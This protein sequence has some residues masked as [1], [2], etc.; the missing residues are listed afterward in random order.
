MVF[1]LPPRVPR[2]VADWPKEVRYYSVLK[3]AVTIGAIPYYVSRPLQDT[4][5]FLAIPEIVVSPQVVLLRLLDIDTF[6]LVHVVLLQTIGTAGCLWLRR[7]HGLSLAS[8]LLVWLLL[9]FNGHVVAHLAIGHSMWG[10]CFFLPWFFACVLDFGERPVDRRW[11]LAVGLVLAAMLLQGSYHVFA[12]CV[13]LLLLL[14]LSQSPRAPIVV[15]LAWSA[16]LGLVRLVPA[17]VILLGRRDQSFQTGYASL[18]DVLAGLVLIRDVTFPR[19]GSGSMGGLQWWEFDLHIGVAAAAWLLIFGSVALAGRR[20]WW[21]LGAPILAMT[22][23]SL[24]SLYAPFHWLGVPLLGAER[25]SSRLLMIPVGLLVVLAALQTDR[26]CVGGR[27]RVLVVWLVAAATAASLFAHSR[28]WTWA[29]IE[30]LSPPPARERDLEIHIVPPETEGPKD[31]LYVA[32]VRGSAALSAGAL[33]LL[34]WRW[35]RAAL[36]R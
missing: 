11:P 2:D 21:R 15:A 17:A 13:L 6:L 36:S 20:P 4:R 24:G 27:R 12:W 14:L 16:A 8:T 28:A 7:R 35:R 26:W 18:G 10:G 31:A 5:K 19:R 9:S 33:L 3:E 1:G 34:G 30:E 32:S 25:V 29:R 22:L 23:L